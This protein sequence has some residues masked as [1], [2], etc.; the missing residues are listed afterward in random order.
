MIALG[1]IQVSTFTVKQMGG[2]VNALEP[3]EVPEKVKP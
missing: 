3:I 1:E 2:Y